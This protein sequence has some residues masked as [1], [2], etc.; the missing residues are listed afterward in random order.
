MGQI[1]KAREQAVVEFKFAEEE[2]L[3]KIEEEKK[4]KVEKERIADQKLVVL[5][6]SRPNSAQ[7]SLKVKQKTQKPNKQREEFERMQR[8]AA[9]DI[10]RLLMENEDKLSMQAEVYFH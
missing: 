5:K 6:P 10:D 7:K 1:K 8:E 3:Q 2:T 4:T 9:L